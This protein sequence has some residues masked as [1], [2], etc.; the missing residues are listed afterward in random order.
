M[1]GRPHVLGLLAPRVLGAEGDH[2]DV[3]GV[4]GALVVAHLEGARNADTNRA[5]RM[6]RQST[7]K[8]A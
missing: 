8:S 4:A 5:H 1:A 3:P 6:Y 2:A 7:Y